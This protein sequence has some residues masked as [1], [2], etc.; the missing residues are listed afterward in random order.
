MKDPNRFGILCSIF[1][2]GGPGIWAQVKPVKK[3]NA[4]EKK[5]HWIAELAYQSN[6]VYLGRRDSISVPYVTPSIGYHDRSGL[7]LAGSFSYL[8]KAGMSRIDVVTIEGGWSYTSD[9]LSAEVSAAKDFYSDQSYAVNSEIKGRVS[10]R[11]SY[12]LDFIEPSVDLGASFS[13]NAD[14]GLG[15]GLE[16]SYSFLKEKLEIDPTFRVNMGTQNYYANYY[17]KRRY[18]AKRN[19]AASTTANLADASKFQVMDYELE[20]SV[21]YKLNKRVKFSF[22]PTLAI[23]VNPST[24]TLVTQSSRNTSSTTTST[25]DLSPAFYFSFG[26]SYMFQRR[27]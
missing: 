13:D 11:V 17:G 16:H 2:I 5:S 8:P 18:S 27:K 23:P 15:F 9:G 25:E 20:S 3:D 24:V 1:L 26:I 6:D 4:T 14:V 22:T 19:N 12:D 10:A 7:F 21:E